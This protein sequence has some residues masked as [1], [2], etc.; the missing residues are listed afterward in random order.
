MTDPVAVVLGLGNPGE[1]YAATRHNLGFLV[2]D[3]LAREVGA[4]FHA[5]GEVGRRAW[6]AEIRRPAGRVV[7]AKPRTYMNRAGRAAVALLAVHPVPPSRLVVVYDDA[8]LELGRVRVRG[9]GGSGGHNGMRSLI[10]VLGGEGFPRV[11]LGVR[12]AGRDERE[13]EQYVL[14]P[15]EADERPVAEGLVAL[16]AEAVAAIL[17]EG[18]QAAMNRFNGRSA[19]PGAAAAGEDA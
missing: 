9:E 13:L 1:R 18:V 14:E 7:L 15:F 10:A 2:V 5:A 4:E 19:A 3:R 8:D 17:D 12:G 16:G 11:R 6:T